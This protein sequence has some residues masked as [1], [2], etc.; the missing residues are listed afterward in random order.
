M[1]SKY[2]PST[3]LNK[4]RNWDTVQ[5]ISIIPIVINLILYIYINNQF[6]RIFGKTVVPARHFRLASMFPDDVFKVR[7]FENTELHQNKYKTH[8]VHCQTRIVF[9]NTTGVDLMRNVV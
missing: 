5:K 4:K 6:N 3:F 9:R 8:G 1:F 2:F 7:T